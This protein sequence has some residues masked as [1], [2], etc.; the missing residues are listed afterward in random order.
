M[1]DRKS[2]PLAK[3]F[4][5]S[6][7]DEEG[8]GDG[9]SE[10]GEEGEDG[11]DENAPAIESLSTIFLCQSSPWQLSYH[12]PKEECSKNPSLFLSSP[13]ERSIRWGSF[14]GVG[15]NRA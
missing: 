14:C 6:Y 3:A 4:N 11:G 1:H 13:C 5:Y 15:P 9:G 10:G 2:D 12:I 8:E 7:N